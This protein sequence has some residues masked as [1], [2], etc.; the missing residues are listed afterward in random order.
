MSDLFNRDK[1][2]EE[3]IA[4][5]DKRFQT[6]PVVETRLTKEARRIKSAVDDARLELRHAAISPN[7]RM[8]L[9]RGFFDAAA[10]E[11]QGLV[12]AE[13]A[14]TEAGLEKERARIS[15]ERELNRSRVD[16]ELR[17]AERR[18]AGMTGDEIASEAIELTTRPRLVTPEILDCLSAELRRANPQEH[19]RF[20]EEVKK[21]DLY[22]M[23]RYTE[24]GSKLVHRRE[25]LSTFKDGKY[26]PIEHEDG[27]IAAL[28]L[29]QMLG[30][31]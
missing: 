25:V 16:S 2:A 5:L 27:S 3:A 4:K 15:R 22:D 30:V 12:D 24:S 17:A 18:Y 6:A 31:V 23:A 26:I 11:V 29:A 21:L 8:E 20:R 19:A 1:S 28:P 10:V 13:I 14:S 7:D 9:E